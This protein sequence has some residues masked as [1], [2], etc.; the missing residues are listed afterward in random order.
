MMFLWT[1]LQEQAIS[2]LNIQKN[3]QQG[4]FPHILLP[5][6]LHKKAATSVTANS[7][8]LDYLA[9]VASPASLLTQR[10]RGSNEF[11]HLR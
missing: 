7:N 11:Y 2:K 8:I 10:V 4:A 9:G 6:L 1:I 3:R 5:V